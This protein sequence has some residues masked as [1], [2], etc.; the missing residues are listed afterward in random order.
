MAAV[1][2]ASALVLLGWG[3][4]FFR[5]LDFLSDLDGA[6]AQAATLTREA[7]I[8]MELAGERP[9]LEQSLGVLKAL[10]NLPQG[11][12][13]QAAGEPGLLMRFG[14]YRGGQ[15]EQAVEAYRDGLRRIMLP[16]LLLRI[17]DYIAQNPTDPM[18]VYQPLKAYLMLGGEYALDAGTVKAWIVHD[19]ETGQF[20]GAD[21][22][23]VRAELVQHLDA[24][25]EDTA[26][27]SAWPKGYKPLNGTTVE[28]ARTALRTMSAPARAYAVM[29]LKALASSNPPMKFGGIILEADEPAFANGAEVR[30]MEVPYFF[31]SEGYKTLYRIGRNTVV[32]DVRKDLWM[33]GE[34]AKAVEM[35][36]GMGE[37]RAGVAKLYADDYI[38][39]WRKVVLTPRP[40]EYFN[41]DIAR[42]I[43]TRPPSPLKTLLLKVRANTTFKGADDAIVKAA[44]ETVSN[45]RLGNAARLAGRVAGSDGFDAAGAIAGAFADLHAYVGDGTQ[46]GRLD[47]FIEAVDEAGRNKVA[48]TMPGIGGASEMAVGNLN[49]SLGKL[50]SAA[51]SAPLLLRPFTTAVTNGG[52][53]ASASAAGGALA[54]NYTGSVL[55]ACREAVD[56][57]YPFY[58]N[59]STNASIA[60]VQ[61]VFGMGLAFDNFVQQ[62]GTLLD[63]GGPV[64]RWNADDPTAATLNPDSADQLR[65]AMQLR[66]ALAGGI[67]VTFEVKAFGAGVDEAQL[68]AGGRTYRFASGGGAVRRQVSW[69]VQNAPE[70]SITLLRGG[71]EVDEIP[72][73]GP[74]ALFRLM[75]MG[76][77]RKLDAQ[78]LNAT[79]G[80]GSRNVVFKVTAPADIDPFGDSGI[81]HFRCPAGL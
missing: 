10:R 24:L 26:L 59:S 66:D 47:E 81:W 38:A 42:G 22:A 44:A 8:D 73:D 70:A 53:A 39:A 40:A 20:A 46:K 43:F 55:P 56:D 1:A 12:A 63:K 74:W 62:A 4:S 72:A 67:T 65:R 51:A 41:D 29:K 14:L 36:S 32:A 52:S 37:I 30:A 6:S 25:L 3:V 33:F 50:V 69:S 64:W 28:T 21:S 2:G 35:E 16:R 31:T 5:N 68:D 11:Y 79:F 76:N 17:E 13:E 58:S 78:T 18:K 77:P 19:W 75:D 48:S 61:R 80:T 23:E 71:Q 9:T 54:Q 34:G 49:Q 45:S 7:G 60:A 15:A 27:L 57:K